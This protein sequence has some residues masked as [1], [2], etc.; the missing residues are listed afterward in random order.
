M[1]LIDADELLE[2]FF[3]AYSNEEVYTNLDIKQIIDNAPTVEQPKG[4]WTKYKNPDKD[5]AYLCISGIGTMVYFRHILHFTHDLY[6][7]D[8]YTFHKYRYKKKTER[9]GWYDID[10]ECGYYEITNICAWCELP[11]MPEEFR[12]E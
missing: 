9:S 8:P 2:Y 1:R 11:E 7:I 6:Q 12:E 10:S 4:E 3:R 5:G